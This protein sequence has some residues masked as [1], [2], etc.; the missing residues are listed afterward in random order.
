MM[1]KKRIKANEILK[2][3]KIEIEHKVEIE[4]LKQNLQKTL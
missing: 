3:L 4:T 2:K 1:I